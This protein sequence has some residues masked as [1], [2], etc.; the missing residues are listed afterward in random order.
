MLLLAALGLDPL[1]TNLAER[2]RK[3]SIMP[4]QPLANFSAECLPSFKPAPEGSPFIDHQSDNDVG[5]DDILLLRLQE[6]G[7]DGLD[8]QVLLFV[9]Y[10]SDP[11]DKVPHT[12]EVCYRQIGGV[13]RSIGSAPITLSASRSP[14]QTTARS[15]VIEEPAVDAVIAYLFCTNG[16][17][18]TS[19]NAVRLAMGLPGDKRVYFCK[20]EAVT[21]SPR[22]ADADPA[23]ARCRKLLGEAIPVLINDFLPT[24]ED[25]RKR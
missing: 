14:K 15:V 17:F 20:I 13:V 22:G 1:L 4:R 2:Y 11:D 10:Y 24:Q 18:E 5:T 23:M 12:P 9:T 7:A 3:T 6:A 19:R 25:L 16:R 8:G 21:S